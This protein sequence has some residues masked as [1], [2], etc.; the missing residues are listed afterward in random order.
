IFVAFTPD[1]RWLVTGAGNEFC[2]WDVRTG[3]PGRRIARHDTADFLGALSFSADGKLLAVAI[4]RTVVELLDASTF[5][6]LVLLQPPRPQMISWIA[7]SPS[8]RQ[9]AV[10]NSTPLIQLWDLRTLRS[11]LAQLGLD[12]GSGGVAAGSVPSSGE[13]T[14]VK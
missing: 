3:Q 11:E 7:F 2:F 6:P 1:S 10:A 5:E 4:S 9:L 13:R 14:G 8:G 12:W